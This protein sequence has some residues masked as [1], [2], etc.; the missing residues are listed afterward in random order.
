MLLFIVTF[1][2]ASLLITFTAT[3]ALLIQQWRQ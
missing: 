2:V 3:A 1:V